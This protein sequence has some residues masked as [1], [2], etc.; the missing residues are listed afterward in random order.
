MATTTHDP[1]AL[2]RTFKAE[3]LASA[4]EAVERAGTK[5]PEWDDLVGPMDPKAPLPESLR[6]LWQKALD[7]INATR[8]EDE[9]NH[10]FP[11][12]RCRQQVMQIIRKRRKER[13]EL[14][15]R[16]FRALNDAEHALRN[17]AGKL[18]FKDEDTAEF[19]RGLM[20]QVEE[21]KRAELAKRPRVG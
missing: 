10:W 14:H 5:L 16:V 17:Q 9:P 3:R 4:L 2:P 15:I 6:D 7:L 8:E 18:T 12:R 13:W 20:R 21:R 11:S 19:L 1:A